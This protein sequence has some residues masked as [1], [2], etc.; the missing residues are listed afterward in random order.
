MSSWSRE[1]AL[2]DPAIVEPMKL[3]SE[4]RFCLKGIPTEITIRL[5]KPVHS[6]K[7][8][9]RRSHNVSVEEISSGKTYDYDED[10]S[11][12]EA[13]QAAVCDLVSIYNAARA[14][15]LKP[16]PGWLT[17]NPNFS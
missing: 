13:L 12:G 6:G 3:L 2:T 9:I 14:K 15:G 7:I 10:S 11:E 17:P 5:Y 4:F 8:V 1:E 16:D